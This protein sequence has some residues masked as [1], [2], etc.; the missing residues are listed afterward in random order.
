[1][2]EGKTMMILLPIIKGKL[3]LFRIISKFLTT[4]FS[5]NLNLYNWQEIAIISIV[6]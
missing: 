2:R 6:G 3:A 4:C 1:M 5:T